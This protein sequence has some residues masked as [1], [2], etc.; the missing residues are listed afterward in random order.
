ML[1]YHIPNQKS[2]LKKERSDSFVLFSSS[3]KFEY[4]NHAEHVYGIHHKV[5]Y[6]INIKVDMH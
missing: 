5:M 4:F 6:R 1:F 3:N 2:I